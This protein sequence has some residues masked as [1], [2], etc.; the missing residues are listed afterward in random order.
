MKKIL[1]FLLLV[2]VTVFAQNTVNNYKYI[3][4]PK[5]FNGF[6]KVDQYQTSS[7]IKFLLEKEGFQAIFDDES[8]PADLAID[9]CKALKVDLVNNSGLLRTKIKIEF[10]DCFNKALFISS[11]GVNKIKNYKRAYHSA[12]REAFI[13]VKRLNYKYKPIANTKIVTSNLNVSKAG[14]KEYTT[15]N[16]KAK[17]VIV[18][19]TSV[20]DK[21][22]DVLY[23]QPKGYGFQL[24]N[25][26][27]EVVFK[28]LKTKSQNT[29]IIKDKNGTF[30]KKENGIWLAEFYENDKLITKLYKVKF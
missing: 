21:S 15:Q 19:N 29:F 22:L 16:K 3:I 1:F 7:L 9:R 11:E 24:I 20:D 18:N 14:K 17:E 5:Q 12:I 27:P 23:A 10:K 30:T 4:V 6:K 28:L 2:S 26:V 13:S 8:I 25:D